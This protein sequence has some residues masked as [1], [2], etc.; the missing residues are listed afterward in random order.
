MFRSFT[1]HECYTVGRK[2]GELH[3]IECIRNTIG[4]SMYGKIR[5]KTCPLLTP[6]LSYFLNGFQY[7]SVLGPKFRSGDRVACVKKV[8]ECGKR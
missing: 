1:T 4:L 7:I 3:I 5:D 6:C 2:I 8:R